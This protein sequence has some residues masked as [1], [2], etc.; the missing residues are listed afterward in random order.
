VRSLTQKIFNGQHRIEIHLTRNPGDATQIAQHFVQNQFNVVA[1]VGGDGTAN[2]TAQ[3]LMGTETAFTVIPYGSG[4]GLARGLSI[5]MNHEKA[6][7][8]ILK[9]QT[10]WIDAGELF[11]GTER[12]MFVGFAGIGYDAFIGKL[13]NERPGRRGLLKY[14]L[15][16][17]SSYQK[18]TPTAMKIK[19][20]EKEIYAKPFVLAVANTN[21]YGNG[22]KIAPH[23]VPDDGYFEVCLLQDMTMVKGFIHGWRLFNGSIDR[24]AETTMMRAKSLEVIP[25]SSVHYHLDGEPHV[26]QNP[27]RF[28]VLHRRIKVIT[29]D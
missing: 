22:A 17:I 1:S 7:R 10:K 27:L 21:Q 18:F 28:N 5:S 23:A 2:E 11:D 14:I 15:L 26:T 9:G 6:I 3:G 4:N 12:K 20:N 24:I 19:I 13:F 29:N 8:A 25:E 16:S